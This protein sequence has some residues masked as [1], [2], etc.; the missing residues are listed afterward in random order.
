MEISE[1]PADQ[2]VSAPW[3]PGEAEGMLL[4]TEGSL[5]EETKVI[6][7]FLSMFVIFTV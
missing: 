3:G 7:H 5:P 4:N 1:N 2:V 6:L